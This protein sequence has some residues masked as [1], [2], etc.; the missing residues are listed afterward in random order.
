M[1]RY[2]EQI[3]KVERFDIVFWVLSL[4]LLTVIVLDFSRSVNADEKEPEK[5]KLEC[6]LCNEGIGIGDMNTNKALVCK[7]CDSSSPPPNIPPIPP[8]GRDGPPGGGPPER[9]PWLPPDR[10]IS[11]PPPE[12]GPLDRWIKG[13]GRVGWGIEGCFNSELKFGGDPCG[14]DQMPKLEIEQ[15]PMLR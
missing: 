6:E 7:L 15:P 2:K 4:L 11:K 13:L 9:P 8:T 14:T 1:D 3:L 12:P 10:P 5:L